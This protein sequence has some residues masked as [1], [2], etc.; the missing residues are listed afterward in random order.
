MRYT[1]LGGSGL[2]VSR[3]GVGGMSFGD[4]ARGDH[5]WTLPEDESRPV[6]RH[7]VEAGINLF[8]TANVYSDGTAEE[9]LGRAL[10]DYARREDVVVATKVYGRMRPGPNGAGLSRKVIMQEVEDSLRRLGTDYIDLYQIHRLDPHTPL[11]ETLVALDDL[12]RSG[13]VLYL[14]AS[15]MYAWQF[16]KALHFQRHNGLA[17][18][19]SMQSQ[20]SLIAREDEREMFPLCLDEGVGAIPWSPLGRGRLTRDWQEETDRSR[21]DHIAREYYAQAVESDRRTVEAVRE[22]AEARG[23]PRAQ[24]ALAW[25]LHQEVVSAPLVGA[26]KISHLDDAIAATDVELSPDELTALGEHYTPRTPEMY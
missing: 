16:S 20:Y 9:I 3:I 18:F 23:L 12:V 10:R 21:S 8:D 26:T 14:G 22:S 15:S 1:R 4:P 2:E 7:A 5:G 6:I 11:E 19:I 17:R 24:V 13:K 25:M